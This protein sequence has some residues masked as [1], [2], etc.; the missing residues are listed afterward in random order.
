MKGEKILKVVN[1]IEIIKEIHK[2]KIVLLKIGTFY[3]AYFKDA[4]IL[5]YLFD[6]KL[7]KLEK[8][9]SNCGFPAS[10]INNVKYLLEQKNISYVLVDRAHNYEEMEK[11]EFKDNKYV[12]CYNKAYKYVTL[13]T[14]IE[15]L[16]SFLLDNINE[17]GI[18]DILDRLER[19]L[20]EER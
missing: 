3:N 6:Y 8:N 16:H 7:K 18:L 12:E 1:T 5:N 14:R 20:N 19:T 11:E 17:E 10:G 9:I 13:K 15:N 4:I 2:D